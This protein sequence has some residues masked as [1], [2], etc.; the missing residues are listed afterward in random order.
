MVQ[1][2]WVLQAAQGQG[3]DPLVPGRAD[4]KAGVEAADVGACT[5]EE[6]NVCARLLDEAEPP[7]W[8]E[9]TVTAVL[10]DSWFEAHIVLP[11]GTDEWKDWFTWQEED[12]DWR[13]KREKKRKGNTSAAASKA[14]KK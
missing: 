13:R 1:L 10:T 6:Q 4:R 3:T 7:I 14:Q 9:A 5:G 2:C 8:V 12:V 11:D